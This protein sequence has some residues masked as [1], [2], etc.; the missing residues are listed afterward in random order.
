MRWILLLATM[1]ACSLYGIVVRGELSFG[2]ELL[3]PVILFVMLFMVEVR[4]EE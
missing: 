2:S 4:D 3:F 1:F